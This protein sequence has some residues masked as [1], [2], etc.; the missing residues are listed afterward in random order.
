MRPVSLK[1]T[2]DPTRRDF[3][4][5][6]TAGAVLAGMG[7][8]AACESAVE[9][10]AS[11]KTNSGRNRPRPGGELIVA[12]PQDIVPNAV[13]NQAA[14]DASW[15]RSIFDTLIG[16]ERK[17][18][19]I[20]PWLA[21]E[22]ETSDGGKVTTLTVRDDVTF[23]SGRPF[24]ADDV[25][26][27][28]EFMR[29]E[30]PAWS[31]QWLLERATS[32][33]VPDKTTVKIAF[34][35]PINNLFDALALMI[36]VD[37]ETAPNLLAAEA[38]NDIIGTG[39]FAWGEYHQG[40]SLTLRRND[41]Y[42]QDDQPFLDTIRIRIIPRPEALM[43]ALRSGQVH[44]GTNISP[45]N[46]TQVKNDDRFEITA[47]ETYSA[48]VYLGGNVKSEPLDD[49]RVRQAINYAIDRQR[50]ND[51]L[52]LGQAKVTALPWSSASDANNL[53][54]A[55]HYERDLNKAKDLLAAAG[56][57]GATVVLETNA[58]FSKVAEIV[59]FNLE[60]AGVKPQL[61][62]LS[63]DQQ[64]DRFQNRTFEGLWI[65]VHG[66]NALSPVD[67][68]YSA[69]PYKTQQNLFNFESAEYTQ[70]A[71]A[72]LTANSDQDKRTAYDA[73]SEFL[74]DQAFCCDLVQ[75]A[76]TVVSSGVTGWDYTVW[77]D[78][79]LHRAGLE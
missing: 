54:L 44:L 43:S 48:G 25:R 3:L 62:V 50:I 1:L 53:E 78:L 6:S 29:D 46:T 42:W 41:R 8:L 59:E 73:V 17:S 60:E 63:A 47:Y 28:L 18:G 72:T 16:I 70:L 57:E 40:E 77:D 39:P 34:D 52:Y 79:M 11:D 35:Q 32:I 75:G 51:D 74:L 22:W 21:T 67:L 66:Y 68:I 56:A 13:R 61:R 37:K 24:T 55:R 31:F 14:Q 15:R 27:T 36:I 23:H 45:L 30:Q 2:A 19:E 4:R 9:Q 7:G 38:S 71:E 26:F 33:D 76:S 20:Q 12:Q 69:L 49:K 64:E 10:Q 65:G 5:L 58:Q